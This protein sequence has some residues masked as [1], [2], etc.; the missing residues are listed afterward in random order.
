M[1]AVLE[2]DD[3]KAW[4]IYKET[5]EVQQNFK[6]RGPG[7]IHSYMKAKQIIYAKK[8]PKPKQNPQTP[9][10]VASSSVIWNG[11]LNS[12]GC[13][14]KWTFG[15]W[16]HRQLLPFLEGTEIWRSQGQSFCAGR[17]QAG[18]DGSW[19]RQLHPR[20]WHSKNEQTQR[21]SSATV[22]LFLHRWQFWEGPCNSAWYIGNWL[23]ISYYT[24]YMYLAF[25]IMFLLA[26]MHME[27]CP[28]KRLSESKRQQQLPWSQA[29]VTH[30]WIGEDQA[31]AKRTSFRY[32]CSKWFLNNRHSSF[33]NTVYCHLVRKYCI[34]WHSG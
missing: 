3:T 34:S 20:L 13:H 30:W 11:A 33:R 29:R 32:D 15:L 16:K 17:S 25:C 12:W 19:L 8:T 5:S 21:H 1:P 24:A 4:H 27:N 14:N 6:N 7:S 23:N 26:Q 2:T 31:P 10:P 22:L 18:D 28:F 9:K